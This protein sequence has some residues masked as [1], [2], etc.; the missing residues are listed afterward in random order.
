VIA[1]F[2]LFE[3]NGQVHEG[4]GGEKGFADADDWAAPIRS[5]LA[6]ERDEARHNAEDLKAS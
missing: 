2:A 5:A 6:A 1:R 4:A 3:P